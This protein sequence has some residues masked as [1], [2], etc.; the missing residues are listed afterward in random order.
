MNYNRKSALGRGLDALI[1]LDEPLEAKGSSNISEIEISK[2]SANPD[3]PR[4]EFDDDA[5][6]ELSQSIAALGI[7]QPVTLRDMGNGK[8]QIIAGERRYRASMLVGKETIPAYVRTATDENVLEMALIENIQREDLNPIEVALTYQKLMEQYSMTQETLSERVGK[9]RA[10]ISNL[11]RMLKL[12]AEIQLGLKNKLI[13]AGHAKALLSLN[14]PEDQLC[15]YEET[16]KNEFS[17]RKVEEIVKAINDGEL[18]PVNTQK[19]AKPR[20]PEEYGIL[21]EHLSKFFK[22]KVQLS[23][24]DKGKGKISIPFKSEEELE[25]IIGIFDKL[26]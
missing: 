26:Q 23:Y 5:L 22:S 9:N 3:Q 21:K 6:L 13:S 2:I 14:N 11:V 16:V 18:S 12:P 10:T 1:Q 15:V 8:Y 4:R 20:L 17:V 7:I 19:E 24:N 25:R